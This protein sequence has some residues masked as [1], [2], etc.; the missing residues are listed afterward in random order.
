MVEALN[1]VL[2][3]WYSKTPRTEWRWTTLLATLAEGGAAVMTSAPERRAA[4][5]K[6]EA[7]AKATA[8][9]GKGKD[10]AAAANSTA[11]PVA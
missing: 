2:R 4:R 10:V 6:A 5:L 9:T 7:A 3:P 1:P 11:A 8:A